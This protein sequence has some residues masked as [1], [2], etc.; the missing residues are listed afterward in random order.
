M[1]TI[2]KF[3]R[4][5]K[6]GLCDFPSPSLTENEG[7][8]RSKLGF[9]RTYTFQD[10]FLREFCP[11]GPGESWAGLLSKGLASGHKPCAEGIY[12]PR[13]LLRP[14]GGSQRLHEC[15]LLL[16]NSSWGQFPWEVVTDRRPSLATMVCGHGRR[17]ATPGNERPLQG[18]RL[19]RP[20]T[21]PLCSGHIR[22][23]LN[24][25]ADGSQDRST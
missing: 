20:A 25:E 23:S 3:Q 9:S 22:G 4:K 1:I 17:V 15:P 7:I 13:F 6:P 11:R 14:G 12:P 19:P 16:H 21:G 2:L 24:P 10:S 18:P 8:F 5:P